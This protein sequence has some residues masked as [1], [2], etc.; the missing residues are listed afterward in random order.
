MKCLSMKKYIYKNSVRIVR[1]VKIITIRTEYP[2]S[3]EVILL[4]AIE[5]CRRIMGDSISKE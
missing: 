5:I 2:K 3:L 1:N 4:F